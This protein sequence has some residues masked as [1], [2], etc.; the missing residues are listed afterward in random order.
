[1]I[2][3]S[4]KRDAACG[5]RT[6]AREPRPAPR[7]RRKATPGPKDSRACRVADS[8]RTRGSFFSPCLP[9]SRS[10]RP[11]ISNRQSELI[12]IAPNPMKTKDRCTFYSTIIWRGRRLPGIANLPIGG[13]KP[14]QRHKAIIRSR[15]AALFGIA[16]ANRPPRWPAAATYTPLLICF[17]QGWKPCAFS[18]KSVGL[19]GP[20]TTR[21]QHRASAPVPPRPLP[22]LLASL[23][24]CVRASLSRPFLPTNHQSRVTNH[25]QQGV[26]PCK[27]KSHVTLTK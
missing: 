19:P 15:K 14:S 4:R 10:A 11:C 6:P 27:A 25:A 18:R 8:S 5:S 23:L 9:A 24:L 26:T 7:P 22:C 13:F 17:S 20:R 21:M 16:A 12:E 3:R 1:M 2:R